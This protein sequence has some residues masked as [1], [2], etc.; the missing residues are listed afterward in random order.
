[1]E[2]TGETHLMATYLTSGRSR[3]TWYRAPWN[4][5]GSKGNRGNKTLFLDFVVTFLKKR[6]YDALLD[7]E[8]LIT[9]KVNHNRENNTLS[10]KNEGK[11]I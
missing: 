6:G 3:P 10:I 11:K 1:M 5:H 4:A 2:G 7:R 8:W 9:A